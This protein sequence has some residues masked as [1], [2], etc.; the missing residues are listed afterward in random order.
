MGTVLFLKL[1]PTDLS[2]TEPTPN[3]RMI[4]CFSHAEKLDFVLIPAVLVVLSRCR[5]RAEVSSETIE[6]MIERE[7]DCYSRDRRDCDLPLVRR[8]NASWVP[9][10]VDEINLTKNI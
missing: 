3:G 8:S 5:L 2:E 4:S 7:Q 1:I 6:S 9:T 10:V